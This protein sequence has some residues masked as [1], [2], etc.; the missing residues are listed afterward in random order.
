[1]ALSRKSSTKQHEQIINMWYFDASVYYALDSFRN[2][3]YYSFVQFRNIIEALVDRPID[4]HS[5]VTIKLRFMQFL[6]RINDG[7]KLNSMFQEPLTP[8]ESAL[9]ILEHICS[10]VSV[11][12]KD[13]AQVQTS[14]WEMLI[15]VCIKNSQDEKGKE[16][17][18]KYFPKEKD[19]TGKRKLFMDL[20]QQSC[21]TR[22]LLSLVPPLRSYNDFKQEM[23]DF[24]DKI[25][26]L[27]EPFLVKMVRL[28]KQG[29][30]IGEEI[31]R[32]P[33][34]NRTSEGHSSVQD[35]TIR[36]PGRSGTQT[37]V[38]HA[39]LSSGQNMPA[40]NRPI[41]SSNYLVT[42]QMSQLE[43]IYP[44]LAKQQSVSV[45]FSQ[46][47][48]EVE[49][50]AQQESEVEPH[51]A[52]L[53]L[54]L[55]ETPGGQGSD[56]EQQRANV[57][58]QQ[59]PD[60]GVEPQPECAE[61]A[62]SKPSCTAWQAKE[63]VQKNHI[64][65]QP[66]EQEQRSQSAVT[67]VSDSFLETPLSHTGS[68]F[69]DVNAATTESKRAHPPA[70]LLEEGDK[71]P[72]EAA[73]AITVAQ[74]VMEE[75]SQLS[76][77]EDGAGELVGPNKE[78]PLSS[79]P[80]CSTPPV[81]KHRRPVTNRKSLPSEPEP[82][83]PQQPSEPQNCSTPSRLGSPSIS[84]PNCTPEEEPRRRTEKRR[85][86]ETMDGSGGGRESGGS[87]AMDSPPSGRQNAPTRKRNR[88]MEVSGVQEEWSDE[89]SLFATSNRSS[90][91]VQGSSSS[92]GQSRRKMWT[93][94]ESS[95]VKQGV[96]RYGEGRW[97]KIKR[98]FPFKGRT[99]KDQPSGTPWTGERQISTNVKISRLE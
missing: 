43:A 46:L 59:V 7:D 49:R 91:V 41:V 95:W 82:A 47:V 85:H 45:P 17:L 11:S 77:F 66:V 23:M 97:E 74:L 69:G 35:Q 48:E 54:W 60:A 21:R 30:H 28:S 29:R 14:I 13:M 34:A 86:G 93:E 89:E 63:S 73:S 92:D 39:C 8:L 24:I 26:R 4:G 87:T 58:E 52:E 62:V 51:L 70:I 71:E 32:K 83:S 64:T 67:V 90:K 96:D 5:E 75:D 16:M 55:S 81:R 80:T 68:I 78:D 3:D 33:Q 6:S 65:D 38:E 9:T 2:E 36:D 44:V 18:E 56:A 79:L 99:A 10:E 98:A 31:V 42:F 57:G 61:Q 94:E 84:T 1:M 50:E 76:G 12:Q 53:H 88:W 15:T 25:Y 72:G 19:S 40:K 22:G 20:L 27:P 37:P